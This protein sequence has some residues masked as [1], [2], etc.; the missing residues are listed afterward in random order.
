MAHKHIPQRTCIAC[1]R[2]FGKRELW[3]I[4]QSM[5]A[6]AATAGVRI[7]TGDT[8]VVEKGKGD[9]LFINTAGIG[10]IEHSLTI[11]P[12]SVRPGDAVILSGDV[13]RHGIAIMARRQGL[14]FETT[15]ESD[16]AA[17]ASPVLALIKAGVE[18]HCL[19]DLT[20][21]GLASAL[22]EIAETANVGIDIDEAAVRVDEQ[23]QGAC[24]ILGFDPLHVANEGR[25]IAFVPEHQADRAVSLLRQ[26][27]VS[28]QAQRIGQ[29]AAT[30]PAQ[31]T[32]KGR[33]GARRILD[34]LSGEQLPRI[35]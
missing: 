26:H 20:R 28:A 11:A 12:A 6:A 14:E 35:C 10:L 15:I 16:S 34:M 19:R 13:G 17:V 3:R 27:P 5:A 22:N 7:V 29:V 9:G 31:V 25:F 8:K 21:G 18:V 1:R 24:E 23:V 30:P 33:I 2:V 4:V 32:L